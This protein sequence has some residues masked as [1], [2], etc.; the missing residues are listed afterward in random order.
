MQTKLLWLVSASLSF[1]ALVSGC[2]RLSPRPLD[3]SGALED[4]D[5]GSDTDSQVD[6]NID[7]TLRPL[8]E[9]VIIME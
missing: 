6:T 8:A 7:P 4:S 2:V 3:D 1:S 9:H 5:T